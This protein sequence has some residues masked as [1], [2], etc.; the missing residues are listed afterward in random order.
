MKLREYFL[1]L[2]V[3]DTHS[4]QYHAVVLLSMQGRKALGFH[5]KHLNFCS[6]DDEGLMGLEHVFA[7]C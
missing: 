3:F 6:E 7:A 1:S 4:R 2:S 5:Q